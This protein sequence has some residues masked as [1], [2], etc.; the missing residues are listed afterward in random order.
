MPPSRTRA[1][2]RF[3]DQAVRRA[4][5]AALGAL[6]LIVVTGAA[7][8]LTQSG[9]GCPDWPTCNG[10]R[11]VAP[12]RYHA[13]V[14][15]GNRMVTI[16]V[17]VAVGSA[18]VTALL[19][20]RRRRDL[21]WLAAGSVVGVFAQ[22]VLGGITVLVHLSPGWVMAH[23]LLSMAVI[24]DGVVLYHRA[25]EPV[26][27]AVALVGEPVRRLSAVM[28]GL[29]AVVLGLGT[30]VTGAGPHSGSTGVAR[31][32]ISARDAAEVHSTLVML[33]IGVVLAATLLLRPAR[34]PRAVV[35]RAQ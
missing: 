17:V 10:S 31:L 27:T 20:E 28:V 35:D 25:G 24:A 3:S 8:R 2:P 12:W 15:F 13:V 1:L 9:L 14:E 33:L 22:A 34:A 21:V 19:A 5:A 18:L 7:V 11:L 16:A 32:P 6:C 4:S 30:V 23:F 26:G 29:T